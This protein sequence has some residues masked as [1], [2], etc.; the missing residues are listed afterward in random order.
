MNTMEHASDSPSPPHKLC[1]ACMS[2]IHPDAT[3]CLHCHSAQ[4]PSAGRWA[5]VGTFLKWIGGIT[6]VLSLVLTMDQVGKLF[7]QFGLRQEAISELVQVGNMQRDHLDYA[8]AWQ[9]YQKALELNP[10]HQAARDEQIQ[11]AMVWL[12]NI[13]VTKGRETMTDVVTPLIPVLGHGVVR[14]EG[15]RKADL[16]A[17]LG[18]AEFLRWRDGNRMFQPGQYYQQA[19]ELDP[20]NAYAHTML[21]HWLLWQDSQLEQANAH[22]AQALTA[23]T[24]SV[25]PDVRRLQLAA[26]FNSRTPEGEAEALKMAHEMQTQNEPMT[27]SMKNMIL[28]L[29]YQSLRT[30]KAFERLLSILAPAEHLTMVQR[31]T[32][33]FEPESNQ[34]KRAQRLITRLQEAIE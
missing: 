32:A 23:A 1:I 26:L 22:F 25:R 8:G 31:L 7:K 14:T 33:E 6:A 21:G 4:S 17:H 5:R 19:L 16:L 3:A 2:P 11:L 34:Y 30:P 20:T 29:Y 15:R 24:D 28:S 12:R 18:W 10:G 9:S 27:S 13:R